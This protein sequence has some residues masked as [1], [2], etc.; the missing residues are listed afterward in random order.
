MVKGEGSLLWET[1][2]TSGAWEPGAG[3]GLV[4]VSVVG[5]PDS[6]HAGSQSLFSAISLN[7]CVY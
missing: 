3:Q 5:H 2:Y 4:S 6:Q 7:M 1:A